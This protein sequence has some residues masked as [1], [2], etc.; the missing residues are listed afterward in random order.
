MTFN[1]YELKN[2]GPLKRI[3][4][5]ECDTKGCTNF[6]G[7]FRPGN[8]QR[9]LVEAAGWRYQSTHPMDTCTDCL[10]KEHGDPK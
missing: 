8:D 9:E 3:R 7:P 10:T 2:P 5:A 1:A 4:L 6:L